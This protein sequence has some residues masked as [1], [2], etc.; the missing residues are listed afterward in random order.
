M[1]VK[2]LKRDFAMTKDTRDL[3]TVLKAELEFV[4][5]GGYQNMARV[6][7]RPHFVFKILRRA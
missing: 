1:K 6:A 3:L 4:E 5:K 7:W 2:L